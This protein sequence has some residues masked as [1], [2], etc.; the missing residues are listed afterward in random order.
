[1]SHIEGKQLRTDKQADKAARRLK[2]LDERKRRIEKRRDDRVERLEGRIKKIKADASERIG[3]LDDSRLPLRRK[4]IDFVTIVRGRK[5]SVTLSTGTELE[6]YTNYRVVAKDGDDDAAVAA[7]EAAG[8]DDCIRVKKEPNRALLA[9][10]SYRHI[11][12]E[13]D[14]LS[15]EPVQTLK[16][17]LSKQ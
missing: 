13:V 2:R 14:G 11:V 1:M 17:K 10:K 3:V 12:E 7:L 8:H 15:L 5:R 16:V 6:V 9:Q 4:L